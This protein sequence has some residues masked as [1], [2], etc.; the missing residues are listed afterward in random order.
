M[1]VI[2]S[3]ALIAVAGSPL[4][5]GLQQGSSPVRVEADRTQPPAE[6]VP[7]VTVSAKGVQIYRCEQKGGA[8]AWV[9][10]APEATLYAGAEPGGEAVGTHGAGPIWRWKDGSAVVGKVAVK[11]SS[12]EP[13]AIPWLLLS[14]MTAPA[15]SGTGQLAGVEYVRRAETHGGAEPAT[16]C[17]A[18]KS[19]AEVRVPYT[20][21]YIFYWSR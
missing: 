10:V 17:D 7:A 6:F 2:L 9:F 18:G 15:S 1:K 19:G 4:E 20:A 5:L 16:G 12:P 11:Q 21:K 3:L 14:A 13:N 8:A